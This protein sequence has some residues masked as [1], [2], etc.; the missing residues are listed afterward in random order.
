[1][2]LTKGEGRKENVAFRVVRFERAGASDRGIDPAKPLLLRAEN[3]VTRDTG[4]YRTTLDASAAPTKLVM[5]AKNFAPPVKAKD[6]DVY[7]T[8][9]S[10][11]SDFPDLLVTD[12]SFHDLHKVTDLGSQLK[13]FTWGTSELIQFKSTDGTPLQGTL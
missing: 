4:F 1:V 8:A 9:E 7:V 3:Q 6:A 11:F 13:P 2:N 5:E 12:G 10:T